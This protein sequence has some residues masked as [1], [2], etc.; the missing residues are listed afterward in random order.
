MDRSRKANRDDHE[1]TFQYQSRQQILLAE[2]LA[3]DKLTQLL[4]FINQLEQSPLGAA[5]LRR[6]AKLFGEC[7]RSADESSTE[8]FA[9]LQHWL[10]REIPQT[11]SPLH[12]PRQTGPS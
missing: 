2:E 9:K 6:R 4:A 7:Q 3:E 5:E 12:S 11:K 1:Q 8:F 10:E